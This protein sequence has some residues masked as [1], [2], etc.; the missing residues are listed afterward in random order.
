[1]R[2]LMVIKQL[3]YAGAYKMFRWVASSLAKKGFD[4]IVFTYLPNLPEFESLDNVLLIKKDLRK[5]SLLAKTRALRSIIKQY[6][7]DCSISFLLDANVYNTLA[8]LGLKTKSIICERNDPFKPKYYIINIIKPLFKLTDG[9]VFQLSKVRAF[10]SI[11]KKPTVVIPNPVF[12]FSGRE[13]KPF[14][15]RKNKIV[16]VGRLD[17]FQKRQDLLI[18]AFSLFQQEYP[19]FKLLIYGDGP[20]MS[21]LKTLV[22][23]LNLEGKVIFGGVTLNTVETISDCKVFVLSSDFEGIPNA[24]TEAMSIGLP[25][26]ATDCSPGGASLLIKNTINGFLVPKSDPNSIYSKLVEMVEN[27]SLCNNI[28]LEAKKIVEDF[29]EDK[30]INLWVNYIKKIGSK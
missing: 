30:I 18:H 10:Y 22:N 12:K 3:R 5:H 16:T 25:C 7:P 29:A 8:C 2:V 24:L 19:Y 4:V 17:I 21:T 9:A 15:K 26:I 28:G 13:I 11:I 6:N 14:E 1:M 20:D 23:D 27:P